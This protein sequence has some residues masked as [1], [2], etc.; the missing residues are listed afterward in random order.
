MH[1]LLTT[2]A[3]LTLS[4]SSLS[5]A[6]T[7]PTAAPA[8]GETTNSSEFTLTT[9]SDVAKGIT[10]KRPTSWTQ[11]SSFVGGVRFAGGDEWLELTV[12]PSTQTL[13]TYASSL[14][15]PTGESNLGSKAFKQGTFTAQVRS[16][17]SVGKSSVTAKPLNLLT[18]RWIF[19]PSKGK[20]AILTVTGPEKV[21]D[22]EGNRD[23]ALSLRLK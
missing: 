13:M 15:L 12:F 6:Q 1:K 16:S 7:A 11:D 22:W 10:F 14:K 23:M 21:F 3:F 20:I 2:L 18:D 8:D 17:K 4:I 5:S 19:S 9:F